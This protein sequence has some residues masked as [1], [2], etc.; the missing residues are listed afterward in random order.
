MPE[1]V[2]E[3][4]GNQFTHFLCE[5]LYHYCS[6]QDFSTELM[7]LHN[8]VWCGLCK[9]TVYQLVNSLSQLTYFMEN[10]NLAERPV[11]LESRYAHETRIVDS[12]LCT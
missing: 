8:G 1:A 5:Y 2:H 6:T 11:V 12:S 9:Q 4:I 7:P 10:L 3:L